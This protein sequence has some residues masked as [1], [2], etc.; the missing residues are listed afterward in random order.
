MIR[1]SASLI[2]DY[3]SCRKKAFYRL[4]QPEQAVPSEDMVIGSI[5]HKILESGW[6]SNYSESLEYA[7]SLL[8]EYNL[9]GISTKKI[10]KIDLSLKNYFNIFSSLV[11]KDDLIEYSFQ[12]QY[13][14]DAILVGKFDRITKDGVV[15]DWKTESVTPS[16]V[17]RDIQ[18]IIYYCSYKKLFEKEPKK[19]LNIS[20]I[21]G[22]IVEFIPD[23]YYIKELYNFIIPDIISEIKSNKYIRNGLFNRACNICQ[24]NSICFKELRN[25]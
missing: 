13:N 23:E 25:L 4:T 7:R 22:K 21:N 14:S 6:D 11:S 15:I 18:Y 5:I 19:V 10:D 2:K 24:F 3:I 9:L 17:D 8:A 20:L 1:L 16:S 12:I